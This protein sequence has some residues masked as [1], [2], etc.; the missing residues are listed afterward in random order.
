MTSAPLL[1]LVED[2]P[3]ISL[4]LQD[5]L[6]EGGYVVLMARGGQEAMVAAEQ[7]HTEFV[8]L[9]TDI[10]LGNGPNGWEVARHARRLNP[11]ISVVY[12]TGDSIEDWPASGVLKSLA[13]QKPV[14]DAHVVTAISTLLNEPG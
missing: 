13:L 12:I 4:A 2:D 14:A 11:T 3:I 8:G 9:I 5:A 10:R 6:E 1:L 7:R